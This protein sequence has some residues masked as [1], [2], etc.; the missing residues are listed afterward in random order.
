LAIAYE[1]QWK[2]MFF[3][4]NPKEIEKTGNSLSVPSFIY[5]NTLVS[6][7]VLCPLGESF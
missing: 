3:S 2:R 6:R 7:F 4:E 1:G 5:D